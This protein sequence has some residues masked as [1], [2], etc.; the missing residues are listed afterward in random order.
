MFLSQGSVLGSIT[1][2]AGV[3]CSDVI[4]FLKFTVCGGSLILR[5]VL[6]FFNSKGKTQSA[7]FILFLKG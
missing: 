7:L 3:Y 2:V 5:T 6:I 1:K 4:L